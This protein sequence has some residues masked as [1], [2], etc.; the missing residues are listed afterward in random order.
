M[1]EPLLIM[2]NLALERG[3]RICPC[4]RGE[5]DRLACANIIT[6]EI[7]VVCDLSFDDL[8]KSAFDSRMRYGF[9]GLGVE[10]MEDFCSEEE[11]DKVVGF[12]LNASPEDLAKHLLL[13]EISH[14]EL[15]L[16]SIDGSAGNLVEHKCDM[17]AIDQIK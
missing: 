9:F 14:I 3:Y 5:I 16:A 8:V 4:E 10:G 11:K 1:N 15:G 7:R 13:H 6:K 17:W 12:Y 2:Q